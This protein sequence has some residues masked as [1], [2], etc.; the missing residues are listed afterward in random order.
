VE[1]MD[2]ESHGSD[3]SR[4]LTEVRASEFIH[5]SED[6]GYEVHDRKTPVS[7]DLRM[8]GKGMP[9]GK[10]NY[11]VAFYPTLNVI[12]PEEEEEEQ[13]AQAEMENKNA[14][15]NK[16]TSPDSKPSLD[17]P[18]D[19]E[20]GVGVKPR[21]S[22]DI[23]VA[24]ALTNG[25]KEEGA[26]TATSMISAKK[27]PK[28]RINVED[29]GQYRM[30]VSEM[31]Q[32]IA[33]YGTESGLIVFNIIEG[34]FAT[35]NVQLEVLIDDNAFPS[36]VTS[37]ARQKIH[38]FN[39]T[40]DAFVRELDMSQ[41]TLRLS[42]KTAKEQDEEES[43]EFIAQLK[44][45]TL[46]TLQQCLYKPTELTLKS[47]NGA[48]SKVVVKLRYLPVKMQL[49]PS[50]SINNSGT[51]RVDVLD[52][53]D[54][55]SADRNGFSDPYC[56][57]R[58]N[59]KEVHK[60]KV[61]KKTLHPAWNEF[62]EIPVPSRTAAN[63]T[64]NVYDWDF[65]DKADHLGTAKIDLAA[66]EPFRPH[67]ESY[68]LD[69]KSGAVRL[70]MLFKPAYVTRH[71]QGSSTFSGTFAPAGKVVGAPVKVVGGVGGGVAKGASFLKRG[72]T[73]S[74]KAS[75]DEPMDP[76]GTVPEVTEPTPIN[77]PEGTPVKAAVLTDGA[78]SP[79]TPLTTH[80]RSRSFG[81]NLGGA[82]KGAEAGT[83]NVTVVS[84]TG[85][86]AGADV[87][88]YIKMIGGKGAKEV[89]KTKAIKSSSGKVEYAL[90]H[91]TFKV[92]CS[93][94]TQFQVVVKDHGTLREKDLGEGLFF[95]SDQG[96]GAEHTVAAGEGSV[97]LKSSFTAAGGGVSDDRSP[98]PA[99][100]RN[101][102]DSR[103]DVRRSL[104]GRKEKHDTSS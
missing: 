24:A 56:K 83:A 94:D 70:K 78:V 67:E 74:N 33:N 96:S 46:L 16:Q 98:G 7:D 53:A 40:G 27:P 73:R 60:T 63:F 52:A 90:D 37:K 36:Y 38:Q 86:P 1:V 85:Y 26:S 21:A 75:R 104:F 97:V 49:D 101:S 82:P 6:G 80:T 71:R 79:S 30:F 12:D 2:T 34:T 41:I 22:L 99:S 76:N 29:L 42:E 64:C 10:L 66:L 88:V 39:E 69:G 103:R 68:P 50:E 61:Q 47:K 15:D 48:L 62:F 93:A 13:K 23:K 51:L 44:G 9:K 8:S 72:F 58:L 43:E 14:S 32:S 31:R 4:G 91:E 54:L 57:F 92:A 3:R 5:E 19:P 55:P 59:D 77:T 100:G 84:A 95:V 25:V 28:V 11:T 89:H 81:S 102:P 65:G 35:T 17:A 45:Q 18:R 20:N 87:R